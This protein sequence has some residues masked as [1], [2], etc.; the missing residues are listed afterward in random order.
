MP[1]HSIG[2]QTWEAWPEAMHCGPHQQMA[3]SLGGSGGSSSYL[4]QRE[5]HTP[6]YNCWHGAELTALFRIAGQAQLGM[7][8]AV[9]VLTFLEKVAEYK[10]APEHY[11]GE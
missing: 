5:W 10:R 6:T 11:T 2:K 7:A 1:E 4:A 9:S 8:N 3:R